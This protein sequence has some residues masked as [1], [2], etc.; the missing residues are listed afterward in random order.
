MSTKTYKLLQIK[1]NK[2][3]KNND[4]TKIKYK[5]TGETI[6]EVPNN[7]KGGSFFI[8]GLEKPSSINNIYKLEIL[9]NI[10]FLSQE[11]KILIEITPGGAHK[12]ITL[13][14]FIDNLI[15]I[16][17]KTNKQNIQ[18]NVTFTLN[19]IKRIVI[20][21]INC[22]SYEEL[23]TF[24]VQN[25]EHVLESI[26]DIQLNNNYFKNLCNSDIL[27]ISEVYTNNII[28]NIRLNKDNII[29]K[30]INNDITNAIEFIDIN[31]EIEEVT[32]KCKNINNLYLKKKDNEK[33]IKINTTIQELN[34]NIKILDY[35]R[36]YLNIELHNID[37]EYNKTLLELD[38][39][40]QQY[41]DI[42]DNTN[43]IKEDDEE[44]IL[45]NKQLSLFTYQKI[46]NMLKEY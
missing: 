4:N 20:N 22:S 21:G 32:K 12:Y 13:E 34:N 8:R 42:N 40:K 25:I 1:N 18:Y 15:Y 27:L 35:Y 45:T 36:Q 19:D 38:T 33:N 16:Y 44:I 31:H 41:N 9:C 2:G 3:F 7:N 6:I 29:L 26:S 14:N 23:E 30:E 24:N 11:G 37:I 43:I 28:E 17:F 46:L 10:D 39:L 5:N